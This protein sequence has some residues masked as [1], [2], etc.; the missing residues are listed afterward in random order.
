MTNHA[1]RIAR[2]SGSPCT[3]AVC[4]PRSCPVMWESK[5]FSWTHPRD[6]V[7]GGDGHCGVMAMSN[8]ET[9]IGFHWMVPHRVG[10]RVAKRPTRCCLKKTCPVRYASNSFCR[11]R[12]QS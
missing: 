6:G 5:P 10:D 4:R 1:L 3:E 12:G 7:D 8:A 2:Y 11:L 9:A